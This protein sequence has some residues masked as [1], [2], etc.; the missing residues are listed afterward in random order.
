VIPLWVRL[1]DFLLDRDLTT[2]MNVYAGLF[3][4]R[5]DEIAPALGGLYQAAQSAG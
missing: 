5:L 3:P 1:P 4:N 2:T